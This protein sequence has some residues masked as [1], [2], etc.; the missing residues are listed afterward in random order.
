MATTISIPDFEFASFFYSDIL[1]ALIAY[2]RQNVPELTDESEFEPLIQMLRAFALVGHL[3]NVNVDVVANESTLPTAQ[4]TEQVRNMLQLIDYALSPASPSQVDI[5]YRLAKVFTTSTEIVNEGAQAAT[6][7]EGANP[8]IPFEVNE[9]LT[10]SPT[11]AFTKVLG[12]DGGVFTDHTSDANSPTTPADDWTPWASPAVGDSV[13]FCHDTAMWTTHGLTFTTPMSGIT[14]RWEYRD[15]NFQKAQPDSIT[16]VGATLEFIIDGYLGSVNQQG[17]TVRVQL[18]STGTY[19]DVPVVWTGS[20]NKVITSLL[21]QSSPSTTLEDYTVGAEWEPFANLTDGTTNFTVDGEVEYDLPQTLLEDWTRTVIEGTTGYW[22]R[23]RI[24]AVTTP[25]S[26]VIQRARMDQGQQFV[27]RLATQGQAQ[28]DAPLGSSNGLPSQRFTTSQ[29]NFINES[30]VVR[31]GGTEWERQDNFL[32]SRATD[33]HYVIE[34]GEDDAADVVFGDG[35]LGKI[36]SVGVNNIEVDYRH[37]A[38]NNG[39]VGALTVTVDKAGLTYVEE[40]YN[41]RPGTGWAEAQGASAGSLER[42]KV[43]GPTSLRIRGIGVAATDLIPLTQSFTDSSGASPYSRAQVFEEGFG[44][45]TVELVVVAK[46]GGTASQAQLDALE[47]QFNGDKYASPPQAATFVA[48]QEV[49]AVNYQQ[50]VIDVVANVTAPDTVLPEEVENA[51]RAVLQPEALK[52][53]GVTYEWDFGSEVPRSR[54]IHEIFE[55]DSGITKVDLT[56]PASD[57]ALT[58]RQLPVAGNITINIIPS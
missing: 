26:P 31:V 41:P 20:Q 51:L 34:L 56:Q 53:D 42:A 36:P 3:N 28:T 37:G 15:G 16:Q 13:Y 54:L 24:T 32:S 38:H 46:G 49:V 2:K 22:M 25:V 11:N 9:A 33:E 47:L 57:V 50:N 1:E 48:N 12:E 35:V 44:A 27:L 58:N 18:N 10:V 52:D 19:E 14:G 5:V 6:P 43:L 39:N 45:K 30:D 17:L 21:G 4:L 40:I 7:A 8:A 55:T 29:R 23:F